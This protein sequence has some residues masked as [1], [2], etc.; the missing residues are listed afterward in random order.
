MKSVRKQWVLDAQWSDAP[1][2]V[3]TEVKTIWR[4]DY[5]LS[6]DVCIF[7]FYDERWGWCP[8]HPEWSE[9]DTVVE[10]S[11]PEIQKWLLENEVPYGEDVWIHWW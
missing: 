10:T 8:Q 7:K 6:N 5:R 3:L 11:Y 9:G 1:E 4:E 2:E